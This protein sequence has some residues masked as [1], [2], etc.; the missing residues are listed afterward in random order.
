MSNPTI[1]LLMSHR[2]IRKFEDKP[3]PEGALETLIRCG[4]QASTSSN[5]QAYSVIHIADPER[6][7]ELAAL[8]SD[9]AQIHQSAA[10]LVFFADIHRDLMAKQMHDGERFDGDYAEALMIATVDAALMMQNV[11]VAAESMGLGICMIGAIR[12]KPKAVGELLGLPPHVFAV[13]G[14]CIGYPAQDPE[15][16]PRLPLDAVLHRER[17]LDDETHKTHMDAY[18][19]AMVEFYESQGMHDRDPRWT[20]VMAGRTGQ[21]HVRIELDEYLTDQGFRVRNSGT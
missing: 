12:N 1:D 11:A 19:Q 17:Y 18:D 7:K 6:K 21:F 5:V 20:T 8:C 9:Q 15:V 16:K 10:F 14:F 4:Q 3:L 2:S 13:S